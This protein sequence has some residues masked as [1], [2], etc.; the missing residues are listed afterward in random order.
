MTVGILNSKLKLRKPSQYA[1]LLQSAR[2]WIFQV[3][4]NTALHFPAEVAVTGLRPDIVVWSKA[5]KL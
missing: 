2:D 1:G 5:T 4:P 3:D